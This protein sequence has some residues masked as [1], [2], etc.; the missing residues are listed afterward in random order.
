[1]TFVT[2]ATIIKLSDFGALVDGAYHPE[3]PAASE[4]ESELG[5]PLQRFGS[6]AEVLAKAEACF[7]AGVQ[8]FAFGLWYPSMKGRVLERR[9]VLDPPRDG[10]TF[11][12]S[13]SGWG[14]IHLRL[15]VTPPRTLQCRVVVNSESR[16]TSRQ[17][18]HPELGPASD[19]DWRVVESYAFRLSRRLASMGRTAPVVQS[20]SGDD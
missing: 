4:S 2:L 18:R 16:A 3:I 10:K 17:D 6:A 11:R 5:A 15:Y 19:W 8:N 20:S 1:M 12:Y 9:V 13:L 7:Q 14:V